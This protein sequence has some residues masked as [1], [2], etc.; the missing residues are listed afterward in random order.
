MESLFPFLLLSFLIQAIF[1]VFA[2]IFKTDRL[3]DLSYGLTFIVLAIIAFFVGSMNLKSFILLLIVLIWSVR[4]TSYLFKRIVKMK[5]DKRFDGIRNSFFKFAKFW[6]LQGIAVWVIL[7]PSLILLQNRTQTSDI[8]FSTILGLSVF[9][10]GLIIETVADRQ[11]YNFKLRNQNGWIDS[12]LWHYSR[13]PNY[14]GEMMCWWGI[15]IFCLSILHGFGLFSIV[16]PIFITVLLL[17]VS[18]IPPLEKSYKAKYGKTDEYKK[19][20]LK[21]N[22]LIPLPFKLF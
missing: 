12:G 2:Y 11:K 18:G 14:F 19:Y 22:L 3:T 13:H 21:T 9:V 15:F 7:L 8:T 10:L 1:F 20:I 4:L 6:V 17:F 5:R 16:G